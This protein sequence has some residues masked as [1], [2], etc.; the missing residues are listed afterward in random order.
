MLITGWVF[1]ASWPDEE[2]DEVANRALSDLADRARELA[3]EKGLLL[4]YVSASFAGGYQ[5]VLGSYGAESLKK[6]RAAA[7]RYDSK[8]YSRPC[9]TVGFCCVMPRSSP[10]RV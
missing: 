5:D 8:E 4:D 3:R 1:T 6:L 10:I 9:K 7:E 2:Q